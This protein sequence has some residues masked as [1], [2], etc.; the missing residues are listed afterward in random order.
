MGI[1]V[2]SIDEKGKRVQKKLL[3]DA[4]ILVEPTGEALAECAFK[5]LTTPELYAK[6]SAAGKTRMGE[7][8]ALDSVVDYAAK[9]LGWSARCQVYALLRG[10]GD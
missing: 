6:M 2:I 1:P 7:P 8:G 9:E 10:G 3:E 4:E 5:V